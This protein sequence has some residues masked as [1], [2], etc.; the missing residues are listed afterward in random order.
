MSEVNKIRRFR[1]VVLTDKNAYTRENILSDSCNRSIAPSTLRIGV[2]NY[3]SLKV[4]ELVCFH[5]T[6]EPSLEVTPTTLDR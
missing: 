5:D 6:K 1:L 2:G 3:Q 4:D